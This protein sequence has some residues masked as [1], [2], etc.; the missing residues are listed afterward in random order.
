MKRPN[1]A[2][3]WAWSVPPSH[4]LMKV[5]ISAS[6]AASARSRCTRGAGIGPSSG[7]AQRA[8]GVLG[9]L[10]LAGVGEAIGEDAGLDGLPGGTS[11]GR[12]GHGGLDGGEPVFQAVAGPV[13]RDDL[14]MVQ[15]TVQDCG[16]QDLVAEDRSPFAEGFVGGQHDGALLIPLGDHL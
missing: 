4:W 14:A 16:G 9:V 10:L 11:G 6:S 7:T 13:D 12:A 1:E 5:S 2:A 15:E 3:S 8:G